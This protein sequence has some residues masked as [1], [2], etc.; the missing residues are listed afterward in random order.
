MVLYEVGYSVVQ[1]LLTSLFIY[2]G[3]GQF[4][5]ANMTS[6]GAGVFFDY[7]NNCVLECAIYFNVIEL[8]ADCARRVGMDEFS[9]RNNDYG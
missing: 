5:I 7:F 2:S 1:I 3:A 9:L 4:L 6:V 8:G